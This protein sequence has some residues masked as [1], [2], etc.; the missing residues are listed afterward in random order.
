MQKTDFTVKY[1]SM[2]VRARRRRVKVRKR[3][4]YAILPNAAEDEDERMELQPKFGTAHCATNGRSSL[5]TSESEWD[6]D[7]QM[8]GADA[9]VSG[10]TP[11]RD[12]DAS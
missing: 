11:T 12:D 2:R 1:V 8:H 5:A 3:S 10:G 4:R 7:R 9:A 6:C